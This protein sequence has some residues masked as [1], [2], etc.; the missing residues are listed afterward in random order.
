MKVRV[1][2]DWGAGGKDSKRTSALSCWKLRGTAQLGDEQI[3]QK[4][5]EMEAARKGRNFKTSDALRAGTDG[6]W[7]HCGEHERRRAVA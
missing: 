7:H 1:H 6:G 2:S 4:I 3:N 5:A